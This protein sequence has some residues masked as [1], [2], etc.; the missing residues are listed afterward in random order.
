MLVGHAVSGLSLSL[1]WAF[2]S[3]SALPGNQLSPGWTCA[4]R[5]AKHSQLLGADGGW[6]DPV[7]AA[8]LFLN[9]VGSWMVKLAS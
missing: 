3:V 2:K 6:K 5:A 7:L 8:P 9:P 4:Q 1:M